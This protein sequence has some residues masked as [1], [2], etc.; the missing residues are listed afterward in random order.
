MGTLIENRNQTLKNTTGTTTGRSVGVIDQI[1]EASEAGV[2]R[3]EKRGELGGK[4]MV[5]G[6]TRRGGGHS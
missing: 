6:T 2:G 5:Q 3:M 4:I 1:V